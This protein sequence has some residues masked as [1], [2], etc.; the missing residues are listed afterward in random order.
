MRGRYTIVYIRREFD[1]LN[2]GAFDTLKLEAQYD[3]GVYI[4]ING[5]NIVSANTGSFELP[6]D[7]VVANRSEDH[8]FSSYILYNPENYLVSGTNVVTAQVIN[9]D[10]SDSSDCFIDIRLTAQ[11]GDSGQSPDIPLN[12]NGKPGKYEIDPVWESEELTVFNNSIQIPAGQVKVGRTYRV[13]CRMKDNTGR[14]SH[15]SAPIQFEAGEPLSVGVLSDLRITELMYNPADMVSGEYSDSDDYEFVELKNIG[16]EIVDLTGVSFVDGITFDFNNSD[17]TS[18]G[19]G[20]FVLVVRNKAAFESLYGAQLSDIIAGQYSGKLDNGGENIC[21]TD[22]WNGTIAEFEYNDGR[23]WPLSCDGGGHS[24]VPLTSALPGEPDGSL[25]YCGNWRA[26]NYIGGSPGRDDPEPVATV[27]LN[28][29]MANTDY[30]NNQYPEHNSNDWIE[31]YNTTGENIDLHDWYLS[32]NL[33]DLKKWVVPSVEIAAYS[34]IS[35]DEVT[36]F[37]NPVS[38][39]FG[40]DYTGEQVFLSYLPG[41]S[42]DRIVDSISYKGQENGISLGR[43]P[44][45][46]IYLFRMSPS[47]D[48]ANTIPVSDVVINELMYHPVDSSDEYIELYNPTTSEIYLEN[49]EGPWHLDGAVDYLFPTGTSIPTDGRLI[50]VGFDPIADNVRLEAFITAYD[51]NTLTAGVDIVGPWSGNLSNSSERLALEKPQ[52]PNQPGGTISWVIIDEIIYADISPWPE[53]ADGTGQA[54][55]RISAISYYSG[56]AP[57][58]WLA[59]FPTPGTEP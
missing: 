49:S 26:S 7:A 8:S 53:T 40:L 46:G 30:S 37:H 22:L 19:P 11:A 4:W 41:T 10:L 18:L 45:V 3:D 35:F 31:L 28:E 39:G 57:D 6:Y 44:D 2:P 9:S 51:S 52:P 27:V 15:W 36:G 16:D 55:Q 24:L 1:V 29:I 33:S 48:C 58:N 32:D 59:D 38:I 56:N 12:F 42:E 5:I 21:L 47:R 54:L 13:R 25:N 14:W 34:T 50:I 17:I 20:E 43:Y 23:D